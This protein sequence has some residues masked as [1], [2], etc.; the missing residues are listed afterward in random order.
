MVLLVLVD[1]EIGV[2]MLLVPVFRLGR[3]D[4]EK[5]GLGLDWARPT[6]EAQVQCDTGVL[7]VRCMTRYLSSTINVASII[8]ITPWVSWCGPPHVSPVEVPSYT[9]PPKLPKKVVH[10]VGK[11]GIQIE[12]DK[13]P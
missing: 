12:L 9:C 8:S 3:G 2:V 1:N 10:E 11:P 4:R 13:L 6:G 7:G 5:V